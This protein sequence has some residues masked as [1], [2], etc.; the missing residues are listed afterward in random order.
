MLIVTINSESGDAELDAMA[1]AASGSGNDTDIGAVNVY[2]DKNQSDAVDEGDELI[3][4][5]TFGSDDGSLEIRMLTPY[6]INAGATRL[7]V[8]YD[9]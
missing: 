1:F 9:F 6:T 4:T 3:G 2:V 7:L 8:T 5:G